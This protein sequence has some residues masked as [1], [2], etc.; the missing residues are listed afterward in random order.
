MTLA[1]VDPLLPP[2]PTE[3]HP[4]VAHF[5]SPRSPTRLVVSPFGGPQ[6]LNP[7]LG[8][9]PPSHFNAATDEGLDQLRR[10]AGL[11][12]TQHRA[13]H[14]KPSTSLPVF[15]KLGM[16]STMPALDAPSR[17]FGRS[18]LSRQPPAGWLQIESHKQASAWNSANA[19]ASQVAN[20]HAF[21]T[22]PMRA[23]H[24]HGLASPT[25]RDTSPSP[26]SHLLPSR[27]QG[28]PTAKRFLVGGGTL[29]DIVGNR[30]GAKRLRERGV[31]AHSPSVGKHAATLQ[32][33]SIP[34]KWRAACRAAQVMRLLLPAVNNYKLSA[35]H[36]MGR[37]CWIACVATYAWL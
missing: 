22:E 14:M 16:G 23:T 2:E 17:Q 29:P 27:G 31:S 25:L 4:A 10:R 6:H 8:R 1:I 12:G 7:R 9:H 19:D 26:S 37:S 5:I 36:V 15:E 33:A 20:L 21:S 24:H 34:M 13:L 30:D 3:V 32:G 18:G 11:G 35:N 28:Q